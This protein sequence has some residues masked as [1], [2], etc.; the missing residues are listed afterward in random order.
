MKELSEKELQTTFSSIRRGIG[1]SF[2]RAEL[3]EMLDKIAGMQF[4]LAARV[5]ALNEAAIVSETDPTGVITYVN[6]LFCRISKYSA[7]EL[8]GQNHRLLKSGRQS[9]PLFE[10][11]WGTITRGAVWRGLICNKAKDGTH[12]WVST[13]IIPEL[14]PDGK[15][16]KYISVRF[17]VSELIDQEEELRNAYDEVRRGS[18]SLQD[19]NN[20][21][22][23]ANAQ[24][25]EMNV[26]LAET[27][28]RMQGQIDALNNAAVVSET[29]TE[30]KIIFANDAFCKLFSFTRE[31]LFG[32]THN[33]VRSGLHTEAFYREMWAAMKEGSVWYGVVGNKSK[34]GRL[35]WC[36]TTITP[37]KDATGR[38]VRFVAVQ[39]DVT[40]QFLQRQEL[41]TSLEELRAGEEAVLQTSEELKATNEELLQTQFRLM[42]QINAL[43]N[44]AIVSETNL[45]GDIVFANETFARIAKY[46]IEELMGQNHR[47]L[48][49]GRQPDG[50]FTELWETITH[51]GVWRGVICNKAKD[52]TFYWVYSCITP[53]IGPDGKPQKYIAVRFDISEQI[54]QRE[55]LQTAFEEI[56]LHE[57]ELRQSSEE[58]QAS[59]EELLVT[60]LQLKARTNALE[61]AAIVS[62]TN[63]AGDIIYAN[64]TFVIISGYSR[65]ELLGQNHRILKSGKHPDEVYAQMW[66]TISSGKIWQGTVCNK[67][68]DGGFYWVAATITPELGRDGKPVKYI[69]IRFDITQQ[70]EQEEKLAAA[71]EIL[72]KSEVILERKVEERTYELLIEKEK[73]VASAHDAESARKDAE[74]ANRVK[75]SFL[76]NMSHELRTPLN[77]VL[78][79][80]QILHDAPDMPFKY[81]EKLR[82]LQTC[83]E[84]LLD[85][86]N[87]VLDISKIEAGKM[88]LVWDDF[89]LPDFLHEVYALFK[90]RAEQK[91]LW[92]EFET[93][94][95]VPQFVRGD[96]GKIRQCLINLVGNALK[97]TTQGGINVFVQKTTEGLIS[98]T[99][100]DTGRGVP[101][102]K[103]QEILTPFTQVHNGL[104]AE[105]GTGLGLSITHNFIRL[106]G[107]EMHVKSE[108]GV[109]SEFTFTVPLIEA[110]A[111][112]IQS[113][114]NGIIVGIK[115]ETPVKIL[116]VDD[117]TINLDVAYGTLAPINFSLEV[118]QS[119]EEAIEK[120]TTFDP[121]LILMDIRMPGMDGVEATR[122]IRALATDVKIVALTASAFDQNREDFLQKGFDEYLTKPYKKSKLLETIGKLLSLS[123]MYE[124]ANAPSFDVKGLTYEKLDWENIFAALPADFCERFEIDLGVGNFDALAELTQGLPDEP[125]ALTQFKNLTLDAIENF[126]YGALEKMIAILQTR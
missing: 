122:R 54:H 113:G 71:N 104:N 63:L 57:E 22:V 97:F 67:K 105:G 115:S 24:I 100:K 102:D 77:A 83:G 6:D 70:V 43:N 18:S 25:E 27:Q 126:N 87:G 69:S 84:N 35:L 85:L 103:I 29:D 13:T 106:M 7:A 37:E 114:E 5:T 32:Q 117:N 111:A 52:G 91:N 31:E 92:L 21:L 19:A 61:Y 55:A 38:P 86:I 74:S 72:K 65:E 50:I 17:E 34:D 26:R 40:E 15:P 118:A 96:E 23:A 8:I 14:G 51:G 79:Y 93:Y 82:V 76:A 68:K 73:A 28:R 62:E 90:L 89:N 33:V 107:G 49:S 112:G 78:G 46:S 12:Y 109:G 116:V 99:V 48:K 56:Q 64:D 108:E 125:I 60:Q 80:A 123:Y 1:G 44:A 3:E 4:A 11:L 81:R 47:I 124:T 41:E 66:A 110:E 75:S 88:D 101:Q 16:I 2:S 42:G 53:E 98:F 95:N 59:N 58:L 45:A 30:G 94:A 20:H 119:G 39:F 10:D 9:A 120:C 121:D 36:E